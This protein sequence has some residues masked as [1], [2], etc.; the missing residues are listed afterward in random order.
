MGTKGYAC[1]NTDE[2]ERLDSSSGGIYPL[3]AK[4]IIENGGIVYAAVYLGM[5]VQHK[6]IT[7]LSEISESCGSKYIPSKLG[8]IFLEIREELN[9]GKKVLFVGT[10][11]QCEGLLSF[12][13]KKEN[14][15]CIDFICHGIPSKFAWEKYLEDINRKESA[16]LSVNMRD[17]STGW[18][19]MQY[20]F[21]GKLQDGRTIKEKFPYNHYLRGFVS[22]FYLR[23]SCYDCQFKGIE[24]LTDITLGDY[25]GVWDLQPEMDDNKGTSLVM[26]HS[27]KGKTLFFNV[28]ENMVYQ[29]VHLRTAIEYNRS[30]VD[31]TKYTS[32]RELFFKRLYKGEEFCKII[33]DMTG[34]TLKK[35][36]FNKIKSLLKKN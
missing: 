12:V 22:D 35:R 6:R 34:Y 16:V 30:I 14:L 19:Y 1:Y 25:W 9:D 36:M 8:S 29:E 21:S 32:K 4:N 3:L 5:E 10:P 11:C 31:S 20:S 17:K 2:H 28:K 33:D 23:P 18:S 27:D 24:R 26:I 7:K 13:G 15:I